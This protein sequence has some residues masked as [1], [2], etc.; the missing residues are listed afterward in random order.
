MHLAELFQRNRYRRSEPSILLGL[1]LITMVIL[2]ACL[3]GYL[4]YAVTIVRK[5]TPI[6]RTSFIEAEAIR[7]PSKYKY[8][9]ILN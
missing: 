7:A 4:A 3:L 9:L 8:N 2:I 5:D 6:I 1:K